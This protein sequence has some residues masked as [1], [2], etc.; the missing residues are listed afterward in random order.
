MF[1]LSKNVT[2]TVNQPVYNGMLVPVRTSVDLR[3][4]YE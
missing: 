1:S 2:K 4:Y 3:L